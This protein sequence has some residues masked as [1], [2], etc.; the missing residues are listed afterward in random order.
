[1][2]LTLAPPL[3]PAVPLGE[4]GGS[5]VVR[6]ESATTSGFV[7]WSVVGVVALSLVAPVDAIMVTAANAVFGMTDE[8][9]PALVA[10]ALLLPPYLYW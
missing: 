9:A 4:R 8:V 2:V 10:G 5:R 6:S 7:Q 1:M 3:G